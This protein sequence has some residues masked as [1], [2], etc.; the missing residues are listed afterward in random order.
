M[1]ASVFS[2]DSLLQSWVGCLKTLHPGDEP[3]LDSGCA[4][5]CS[6]GKLEATRVSS[7]TSVSGKNA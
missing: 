2:P 5:L 3:Q 6:L 7:D 4:L 1:A